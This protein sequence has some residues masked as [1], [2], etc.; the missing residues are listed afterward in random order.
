M[1]A[2]AS[3]FRTTSTFWELNQRGME[4]SLCR[5]RSGCS[6]RRHSSHTKVISMLCQAQ[7]AVSKRS[8]EVGPTA[9]ATHLENFLTLVVLQRHHLGVVWQGTTA[10]GWAGIKH[11]WGNAA[12]GSRC[13]GSADNEGRVGSLSE[14]AAIV[15]PAHRADAEQHRLLHRQQRDD[16]LCYQAGIAIR[17]LLQDNDIAR[18]ALQRLE[19]KRGRPGS[20]GT[21]PPQAASLRAPA[22]PARVRLCVCAH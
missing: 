1:R 8:S 7:K 9:I 6:V 20:E 5:Q 21:R 17:R 22:A 15:R 14:V 13:P 10:S 18:H 16:D 19:C 12:H 2:S 4:A 11:G 3:N